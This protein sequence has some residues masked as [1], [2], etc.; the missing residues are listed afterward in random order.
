MISCCGQ[1]SSLGHTE[2]QIDQ[3]GEEE[4]IAGKNV[5][6]PRECKEASGIER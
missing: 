3:P 4:S 1:E 5:L 2:D 6:G